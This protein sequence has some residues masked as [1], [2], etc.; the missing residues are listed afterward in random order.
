MLSTVPGIK[1]SLSVTIFIINIVSVDD[2][3]IKA[4]QSNKIQLHSGWQRKEFRARAD[5]VSLM[6][7]CTILTQQSFI[8]V[9]TQKI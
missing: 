2:Y 9:F 4:Q 7:I 8:G 1:G 5:P 6:Q 3:I